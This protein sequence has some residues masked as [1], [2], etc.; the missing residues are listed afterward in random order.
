MKRKARMMGLLFVVLWFSV[1]TVSA[2]VFQQSQMTV[3][4]TVKEIATITLQ[5]S[6]LG[7]INE[8]ET[9][10]YTKA[11]VATLGNAIELVTTTVDVYMHLNS[12]LDS[13]DDYSTYSI[14]VKYITVPGGSAHNVGDTACTLTK[15]A[16]D[17]AGV[18]LD[19]S[20]TWRFD[21]EITTTASS[22]DAD[23]PTTVTIIVTAE[24][25]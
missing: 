20:G 1:V 11:E 25:T 23:T 12:D 8:G 24:S 16:P 10:G 7:N 13:Q 22:V 2:Y 18:T 17:P 15:A 21:L 9:K 5:N 6:A 4:Q 19:V 14:T 3:T